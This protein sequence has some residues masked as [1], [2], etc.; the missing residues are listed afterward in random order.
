MRTPSVAGVLAALGFALLVLP[1]EALSNH[2][3]HHH[4]RGRKSLFQFDQTNTKASTLAATKKR[5]YDGSRSAKAHYLG[6]GKNAFARGLFDVDW[7]A[8]A[9]TYYGVAV[10]LHRGFKAA[11]QGQVALM[12]TDNWDAKPVATDRCGVVI[13][14]SNRRA[15]FRCY[16]DD[17]PASVTA[18]VGPFNIPAG[19]WVWLEVHQHL[20]TIPGAALT[21]VWVDRRL[22]GQTTRPNYF[23]TPVSRVR[24]GLV[25]DAG[26]S[27]KKPLTLY[28]DR[29]IASHSYVR[30]LR[31]RS[32]RSD[33]AHLRK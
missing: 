6:T 27:Q 25:A 26:A 3:H 24:Y 2:H 14:G 32:T 28:F 30:P 33:P 17:R 13:D 4:H 1:A 29:A 15:H 16:Q 22:V 18:S 11:M 21:Q 5:A 10:F 9:D 19:R 20:S 12:R 23:G 31:A 7:T 8:G